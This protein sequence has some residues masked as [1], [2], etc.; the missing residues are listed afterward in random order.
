MNRLAESSLWPATEV[1]LR[2]IGDIKPSPRNVRLHSER[3]IDQIRQSLRD[4]GWTTPVLVD[5]DGQLIAGHGRLE[6]AKREGIAEVPV[7]VAAG[8]TEAQRRAYA[9]A[10]NKIA[11]NS[12]W[13]EAALGIELGELSGLGVDLGTLG[14]DPVE[15]AHIGPADATGESSGEKV[16]P[17]APENPIAARGDLWVIGRH[18][19]LIDD[20]SDRSALRKLF[21]DREVDLIVTSPPYNQ[22]IEKFKPSGM[23]KEGDWAAKVHRLAYQDSMPEKDY[24]AWQRSLL[25]IWFGILR[26]GG[27]VFYNHKNRYREKRVVSPLEWLPGK[28]SLR[29]EIIWRR[30][31]SVTQNA[32]MFLPCDERIY[33]LYKGKDFTFNDT[34]EIKTWSSVWDIAPQTNKQ[35]AV[36][37]PMELPLR[38]IEACSAAENAVFDPFSG[39]GTTMIAC[40][41]L[42]RSFFGT[43]LSPANGDITILRWQEMTGQKATLECDGRTFDEIAAERTRAAA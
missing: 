29:Q 9:L 31:G 15:T 32:R 4:Y 33:W 5:E 24:Q 20:T 40:E 39:S 10:D 19:L 8:W 16:I 17:D 14:F 13:D 6:A 7:A 23:H 3:Q 21:C 12:T 41:K 36:A 11:L 35:H 25:T 27:S 18:R 22:G 28:F 37:F 1:R 42:G 2:P 26:D 30:P 38:C 34:T 43:E